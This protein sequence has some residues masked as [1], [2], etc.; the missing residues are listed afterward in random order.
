M[1]NHDRNEIFRLFRLL[2]KQPIYTFPLARMPLNAPTEQGVYV[3]RNHDGIV[4][5]VGETPRG[6]VGLYNRLKNHLYG[7]SSFVG[8]HLDGNGS[9]LRGR[10][11][12]QFLAIPEP[13][14]R[15]LLESFA[16]GWLCPIHIHSSKNPEV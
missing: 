10:Y 4:A 3:I 14:T 15:A 2:L 13:R 7:L 1:T 16:T 5:Y 12:Y 6:T 11:T 8:S 9:L